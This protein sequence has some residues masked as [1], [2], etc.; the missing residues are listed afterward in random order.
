LARHALLV[1]DMQHE[2]LDRWES[3]RVA[4]LVARTNALVAAF[5]R[6]GFPVIWVR[7][8]HVADMSD[9]SLAVRDQGL[10]IAPRGTRGAQLHATL[11]VRADDP[12]V[13]KTRYSA[14]FG[15]ELDALLKE[16]GPVTLVIAGVNTHACVRMTAIDAYQRDFRIILAT[17]CMDSNDP[18][19]ARVS[20]AYMTGRVGRAMTGVAIAAEIERTAAA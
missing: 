15:T 19:H 18:E 11:D 9:A 12:V 8:E 2:F 1:I 6:A 17:D 20:L 4:P 7:E 13:V 5:R 10:M 14:F 16:L 3:S